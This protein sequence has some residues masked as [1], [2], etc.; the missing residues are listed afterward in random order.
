MR[1]WLW[2]FIFVLFAVVVSAI[3]WS[4]NRQHSLSR[5]FDGTRIGASESEIFVKLGKP[6]RVGQCGQMFGGDAP[7]FCA[8]EYLYAS[9]YAPVRP[10]YWAF[11]F[12]DKK[13]LIQKYRYVSP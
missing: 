8:K 1:K 10:E 12:N 3:A 7:I 6:W 13:Q 4:V 2:L 9:P 11:R 5:G